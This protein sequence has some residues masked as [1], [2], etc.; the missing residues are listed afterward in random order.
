MPKHEKAIYYTGDV[1]NEIVVSALQSDDVFIRAK[2]LDLLDGNEE[3]R[4]YPREGGQGGLRH[5]YCRETTTRNLIQRK[6]NS[7]EHNE[8]IKTLVEQLEKPGA[9]RLRLYSRI[10]QGWS[11]EERELAVIENYR[12]QKEVVLIPNKSLRVRHD[13]FGI[14]ATNIG[15][16]SIFPWVAIEVIHH[17]YPSAESFAAMLEWSAQIPLVIIFDNVAKPNFFFQIKTTTSR[18]NTCDARCIFYI[19]EGQLWE[20]ET[21]LTPNSEVLKQGMRRLLS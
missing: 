2:G 11:T 1:K 7:P 12:W 15:M 8:R 10:K 6:E 14:R 5:F 16:S 21:P 3:H 13:I 9:C 17:H 20:N 19:Y 4:L 18:T